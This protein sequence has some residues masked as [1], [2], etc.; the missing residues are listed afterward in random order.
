MSLTIIP[1]GL[2]GEFKILAERKEGGSAPA[3]RCEAT[4]LVGLV[5]KVKSVGGVIH[6]HD[7]ALRIKDQAEERA[8]ARRVTAAVD[9]LA[10]DLGAARGDFGDVAVVSV[11]Y[12]NVAVLSDRQTQRIVQPAA[13]GKYRAGASSPGAGERIGDD[14]NAVV[15]TVGHVED[16]FVFP[17][18]GAAIA[19]VAAAIR[20]EPNPGGPDDQGGGIRALGKS[21]TNHGEGLK[22]R[23]G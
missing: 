22:N 8:C 10:G 21:R 20:R 4:R 13:A 1:P 9:Q 19:G 16:R 7:A 2:Q 14:G 12:E 3:L 17:E 15:Q 6:E 5:E 11:D 23:H 18:P